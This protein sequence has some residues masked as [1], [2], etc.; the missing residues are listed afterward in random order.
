MRAA[1]GAHSGALRRTLL[2]ESLLLCGGG[3]VL[4]VLLAWPLVQVLARYG[5]RFS[6]RALEATVDVNLLI[7]GVALALFAAVLLM[8]THLYEH[9]GDD[10][11][12]DADLWLAIDRFL[13]RS[14]PFAVA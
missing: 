6:L 11:Q 3:A 13:V 12:T 5:S 1:L 10:P 9:R 4:G 8:L 7:V 2:A 14:K